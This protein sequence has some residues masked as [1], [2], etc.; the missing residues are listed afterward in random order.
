LNIDTQ[1]NLITGE[2]N[3]RNAFFNAVLRHQNELPS[4]FT[5]PLLLAM[6]AAEGGADSG[7]DNEIITP[8]GPGNADAK[9]GILQVTWVSGFKPGY[10]DAFGDIRTGYLY[11]NNDQGFDGNVQDGIAL[12]NDYYSKLQNGLIGD[13][14]GDAFENIPNSLAIKTILHY[15]GGSDPIL[16]YSDPGNGGNKNYLS[17]VADYLEKYVPSVFGISDTSSVQALRDAQQV[18]DGLLP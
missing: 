4:G 12:L 2:V 16:T 1:A 8:S 18:L 9:D 15:N 13:G 5:I 3:R 10:P 17:K 14:Y 6:A 7:W 11:E